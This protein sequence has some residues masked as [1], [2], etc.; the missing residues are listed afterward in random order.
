MQDDADREML[1][2][3]A[4]EAG[5]TAG[6]VKLLTESALRFESAKRE[7]KLP[8]A[9]IDGRTVEDFLA[10][11]CDPA[12]IEEI[13]VRLAIWAGAGRYQHL[14][15]KEDALLVE[16]GLRALLKPMREGR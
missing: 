5:R 8:L 13:A 9:S 10:L 11:P 14:L 4:A 2:R 12:A 7:L 3:L 15:N 6:A 1:E 16:D